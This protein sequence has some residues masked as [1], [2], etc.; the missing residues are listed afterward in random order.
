ME[1]LG[2]DEVDIIIG[3]N[4]IL[5][6]DLAVE[7][8]SLFSKS[9]NKRFK[10]TLIGYEQTSSEGAFSPPSA[11]HRHLTPAFSEQPI[12]DF[13]TQESTES[14]T[15]LSTA[16]LNLMFDEERESKDKYITIEEDD[17]QIDDRIGA[18]PLD[19]WFCDNT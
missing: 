4:E 6:Y 15:C 8:K 5:K 11:L 14:E 12:V 16:Y 17:D 13:W 1:T 3:Y 18:N 19:A 7:F 10:E 9:K 2:S